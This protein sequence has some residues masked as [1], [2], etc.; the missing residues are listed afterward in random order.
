MEGGQMDTGQWG[1]MEGQTD[2]GGTDGHGG[3]RR[4]WGGQTD[5]GTH[6]GGGQTVGGRW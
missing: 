5:M 2:M 4:T 1:D 3:D 6:V